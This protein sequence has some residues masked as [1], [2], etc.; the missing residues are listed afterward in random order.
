MA[1]C[2]SKIMPHQHRYLIIRC[3]RQNVPVESFRIEK[4][5]DFRQEYEIKAVRTEH[6]AYFIIVAVD[7]A[8]KSV[9]VLSDIQI[10]DLSFFRFEWQPL[11]VEIYKTWMN[12]SI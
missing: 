12:H 2:V 4:A 5:D 1:V 7:M 3:V 9:C 6:P 10:D 11:L 8:C